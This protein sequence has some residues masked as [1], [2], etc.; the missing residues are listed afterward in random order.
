MAKLIDGK[1]ISAQIRGELAEETKA[2]IA[3]TGVTPGL[4]VIIVGDNPASRVYV[5]GKKKDCGE[6]GIY[7]EEYALLG[8]ATQEELLELIKVL[9]G[10]EDID[11]ILVQLPLPEQFELYAVPG[12][13][14]PIVY[15]WD[16]FPER[17]LEDDWSIYN[18]YNTF[19][20][21]EDGKLIEI[22]RSGYPHGPDSG[23]TDDDI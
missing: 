22:W 15:R 13:E 12:G 23:E 2:L 8:S 4:A 6:C 3:E 21:F 17:L 1:L 14:E 18:E 7:S 10:R 16:E 5:N 20:T 11:G 19:A 9:N